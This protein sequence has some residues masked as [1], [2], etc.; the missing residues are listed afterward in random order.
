ME[1]N[2]LSTIVIAIIGGVSGYYIPNL[3]KYIQSKSKQILT[4]QFD[5]NGSNGERRRIHH[6]FGAIVDDIDASN[7]RAWEHTTKRIDAGHATCYGPYTKE[8]S[9]RGKYKARFRIKAV[10]II[11][12]N[13][14]IVV[15]DITHGELDK[16]GQSV[17]LGL[18][19]VERVILGK[20]L[21]NGKYKKFD[22]SFEYDGQSSI[23]FRCAVTNPE[24]FKKNVDRILFDNVKI[25]RVSEF[26]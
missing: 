23:E 5:D 4:Y 11:N 15:L 13:E 10:G 2:F 7:K 9:Y 26:V 6:S 12:P 1:L 18:P 16:N 24:N 19:L 3:I 8:I 25:Y 22:V 20:N 14:S 21:V 17:I